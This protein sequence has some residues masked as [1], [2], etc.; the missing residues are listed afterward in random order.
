[1]F[2]FVNAFIPDQNVRLYYIIKYV[3]VVILMSDTFGLIF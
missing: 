1:M 3:N 2:T